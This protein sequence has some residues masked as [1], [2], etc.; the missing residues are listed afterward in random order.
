MKAMISALVKATKEE[1][2]S[3]VPWANPKSVLWFDPAWPTGVPNLDVELLRSVN[4]QAKSL[5]SGGIYANLLAR[6]ALSLAMKASARRLSNAQWT[7][8]MS[9]IIHA[10][11]VHGSIRAGGLSVAAMYQAIMASLAVERR[12]SFAIGYDRQLRRHIAA[13]SMLVA[14]AALQ[15]RVLDD[16]HA[17]AIQ[18]TRNDKDRRQ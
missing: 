10:M 7:A 16:A 14:E 12:P 3:P 6:M 2:G 18:R 8:A 13:Q 17:A 5:G 15:F 11:A 4:E 1:R 9:R